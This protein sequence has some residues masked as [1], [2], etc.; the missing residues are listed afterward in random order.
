MNRLPDS[1][2]TSEKILFNATESSIVNRMI[3][4][5]RVE[6]VNM[7]R[8]SLR[9]GTDFLCVHDNAYITNG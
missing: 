2:T 7:F 4:S 3:L 9:E 5:T 1:I 8:G 6:S